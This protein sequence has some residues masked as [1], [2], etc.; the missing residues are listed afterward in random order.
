M[1]VPRILLCGD[2]NSFRAASNMTVEIVGQISFDGSPERGENYIFPN[3][4]DV[5]AYVPKEL[6]IF[7]NGEEIS[8]DAL[9]QILNGTADYI[10]FDDAGE[11]AARNNDLASL[12][13]L[14]QFIPREVLFRQARQNFYTYQN[15]EPLANILRDNKISRCTRHKVR[16]S[17]RRTRS[18]NF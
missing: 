15:M 7:L 18:E 3:P 12:K 8:G 2:V 17:G 16:G 11:Y 5:V 1:Y 13:I 9:R 6:H 4:N 14:G 10:V